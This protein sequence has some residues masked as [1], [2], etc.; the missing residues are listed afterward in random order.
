VHFAASNA[1]KRG[2]VTVQVQKRVHLDG[3]FV[4][5]EF[6]PGEQRKAQIDGSRVQRVQALIQLYADWISRIERPGEVDQDLREVRVDAPVV[7]F[8]GIGQRGTRHMPVKTHVVKLAS[9]RSQA[10]FYVAKTIPI[11]QLGKGHRQILIPTREA[12]R[13]PETRDPAG[14]PTTERRRFG[15]D[16]RIIVDHPDSVIAGPATFQIAANPMPVQHSARKALVSRQSF[17]SRTVVRCH[18]EGSMP[19]IYIVLVLIVVGMVLWLINTYI[20]MARSIKTILNAVVVIAVCVW[21][22]K[23][24][25]LWTQVLNY[26]I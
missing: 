21:V 14:S 15:L 13:P 9:Q 4:R 1:D 16:S 5:P 23:A 10:R 11:S 22:L 8:V 25:G 7:R 17:I 12:S 6:S 24:A 2:D 26:R 18:K 20:P 19:L 3:G